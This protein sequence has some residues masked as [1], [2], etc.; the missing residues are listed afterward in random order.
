[1]FLAFGGHIAIGYDG[2]TKTGG[3]ADDWGLGMGGGAI[4]GAPY[5]INME[6]WEPD[7]NIGSQDNQIMASAVIAPGVKCGLQVQRP[8]RRRRQG[9]GR[10][11]PLR[12]DHQR[13]GNDYGGVAVN[14]T[15][16]TLADDPATP[17]NEAG[18][19][20]FILDPGTYTVYEIAEDR[21]GPDAAVH[22]HDPAHGRDHR[23]PRRTAPRATSSTMVEAAGPLDERL[24]QPRQPG[25]HHRQEGDHAI[26]GYPDSDR[27]HRLPVHGDRPVR[28]LVVQRSICSLPAVP[29][30]TWD[31]GLI[32]I[33]TYVVT[34]LIG[35]S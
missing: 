12:L 10:A 30:D 1:M 34:E 19:Y 14:K 8:R 7:G 5:H 16:T 22:R 3:I 15:T 27:R 28:P 31:S 25:P 6:S 2:G 26:A 33:G 32:D 24:R 23:R 35:T 9:R 18:Y 29:S 20:E 4:S 13:H 11:R 17:E 21:L